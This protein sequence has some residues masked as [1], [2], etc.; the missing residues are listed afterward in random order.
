MNEQR[1]Q[2]PQPRELPEA[3]QAAMENPE[4]IL[5]KGRLTFAKYAFHI[6]DT[7]WQRKWQE[8]HPK[9]PQPEEF[10]GS[11][12]DLQTA[13][14]KLRLIRPDMVRGI[15]KIYE[16]TL[17][18]EV[19]HL[20]Y[21]VDSLFPLFD[22]QAEISQPIVLDKIKNNKDIVDREQEKRILKTLVLTLW[23]Q[24]FIPDNPKKEQEALEK[25]A[26]IAVVYDL[27][28]RTSKDTQFGIK[29]IVQDQIAPDATDSP[30]TPP[31]Q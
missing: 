11:S 5:K 18:G 15:Y 6:V 31:T 21:D 17:Q 9:P 16:T 20:V 3:W 8:E 23:E 4:S 7:R 29:F 10:T 19:P 22:Q 2:K 30:Q 25:V 28:A 14:D 12:M 24:G 26:F 1:E 13:R 27:L